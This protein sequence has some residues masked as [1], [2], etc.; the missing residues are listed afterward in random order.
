M[1]DYTASQLRSPQGARSR[2]PYDHARRAVVSLSGFLD[3]FAPGPALLTEEHAYAFAAD[4]RHRASNGLPALGVSRRDGRP[5]VVTDQSR[6]ASLN[7]V[8][9]IMR[10]TPETPAGSAW[11]GVHRRAAQRR[12]HGPPHP[13][14]V[15]RRGRP[16]AGRRG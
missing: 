15:H 2:N 3:A 9:K 10:W 5:S 6:H 8:R 14:P 4:M 11:T 13:R 1:W 16:R 7:Y 12:R